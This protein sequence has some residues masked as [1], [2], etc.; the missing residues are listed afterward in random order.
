M[1]VRIVNGDIIREDEPPPPPPSYNAR[2]P[3]SPPPV[4][5]QP[6]HNGYQAVPVTNRS[7][8]GG[9]YQHGGQ[10]GYTNRYDAFDSPDNVDPAAICCACCCPCCMGNPCHLSWW[11]SAA[12]TWFCTFVGVWSIAQFVLYVAMASIS[13]EHVSDGTLVDFGAINSPRVVHRMQVYRLF[14][15]NLLTTRV[16]EMLSCVAV[17][18]LFGWQQ[19]VLQ[20]W[21]PVCMGIVLV[22]SGLGSGLTA[23]LVHPG[24]QV[25]ANGLMSF[26]SLIG[27]RIAWL[28]ASWDIKQYQLEA[29]GAQL[30]SPDLGVDAAQLAMF[31][32]ATC[33]ETGARELHQMEKNCELI[34]YVFMGVMI[35]FFMLL[36]SPAGALIPLTAATAGFLVGGSLFMFKLRKRFPVEFSNYWFGPRL[37]RVLPELFG[38]GYLV[39]VG[40]LTAMLFGVADVPQPTPV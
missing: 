14:S 23:C 19:E 33:T 38:V 1:P 2:P 3:S 5:G 15:A 29:A 40:V 13:S 34:M 31:M 30:E 28:Y 21:G 4:V 8:Q 25:V 36:S 35:A 7:Y 39:M 20:R 17:Q 6:V 16:F 10:P 18:M 11:K 32:P 22:L 9:G 12:R 37:G 26:V 27:A 24:N